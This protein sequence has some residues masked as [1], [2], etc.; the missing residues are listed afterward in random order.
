MYLVDGGVV[1]QEQCLQINEPNIGV[2]S[3]QNLDEYQ[4]LDTNYSN[5]DF[6]NEEPE[7]MEEENYL[8]T[9]D[10]H[11]NILEKGEPTDFGLGVSDEEKSDEEWSEDEY[12]RPR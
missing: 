9:Q 4:N 10:Q 12:T 5:Q 3:G 7:N 2:V 1:T 6:G 8:M 11:D